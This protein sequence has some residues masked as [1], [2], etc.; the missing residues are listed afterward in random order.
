MRREQR[1]PTGSTTDGQLDGERGPELTPRP[2]MKVGNVDLDGRAPG[3]GRSIVA[4]DEREERRGAGLDRPALEPQPRRPR[5]RPDAKRDRRRVADP[6]VHALTG[7]HS[8]KRIERDGPGPEPAQVLLG[9][10][11]VVAEPGGRT[12]GLEGLAHAVR[13]RA[14]REKEG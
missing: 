8:R 13:V 4:H 10:P 6:N 5:R 9:A 14:P 12:P 2:G 11:H 3:S 7:L 1:R